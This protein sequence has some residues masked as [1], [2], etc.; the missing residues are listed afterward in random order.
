VCPVAGESGGAARG[1]GGAGDGKDGAAAEEV[2]AVGGRW[3]GGAAVRK[4]LE[5]AGGRRDIPC[6]RESPSRRA[7]ESGAD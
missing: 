1:R 7:V 4:A 5:G 2:L 6:W 3:D